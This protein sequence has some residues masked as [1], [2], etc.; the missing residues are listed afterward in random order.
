MLRAR[1]SRVWRKWPAALAAQRS[2]SI[3]ASRLF[4]FA[5][6]LQCFDLGAQTVPAQASLRIGRHRDVR[7][8]RAPAAAF[9][10]ARHCSST[11]CAAGFH[12]A[13]MAQFSQISPEKL[14]RISLTRCLALA[15]IH[16]VQT[17]EFR[18]AAERLPLF[19]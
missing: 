10:L 6:L 17:C 1:S 16:L 11:L 2:R 12:A 14:L 13:M 4:S 7:Q 15:I 18:T 9:R 8:F 5:G 3:E 19:F